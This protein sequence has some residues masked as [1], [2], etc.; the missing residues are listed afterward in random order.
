MTCRDCPIFWAVSTKSGVGRRFTRRALFVAQAVVL[1]KAYSMKL[2]SGKSPAGLTLWLAAAALLLFSAGLETRA[3]GEEE[4]QPQPPEGAAQPVR[5]R[6]EEINLLRLLNLT[7]EQVPQLRAIRQQSGI[8]G[9]ALAR[10]LNQ[11]R[12]ALDEAI[13]ADDLNED[14]IRERAREVAEAQAAILR[15]RTQTEVR[16]RRVLTPEQLQRFRELRREAQARQRL[17]RQFE[18]RDRQQRQQPGDAFNNRPNRRR[19]APADNTNNP[20]PAP[21]PRGGR[22]NALN[23]P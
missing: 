23:R 9:Q 4:A 12:R 3:Q 11:A 18:R 17:Q 2:F 15:L 13:Y 6:D 21:T 22:R 10:R 14:V 1:M 5:P 16:V 8:E 7:P 19:D 20:R